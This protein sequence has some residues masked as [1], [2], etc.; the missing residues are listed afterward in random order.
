[1]SL[2][3]K[4][5][6]IQIAFILV[7]LVSLNFAFTYF[8][9]AS[10]QQRDTKQMER[11]LARAAF[12]IKKEQQ[13][14]YEVSEIWAKSDATWEF[15]RGYNP[16]FEEADINQRVMSMMN[17]SSFV[18]FDN[19]NKPALLKNFAAPI[20]QTAPQR[21]FRKLIID[22]PKSAEMLKNI[23]ISGVKGLTNSGGKPV[24]FVLQPILNPSEE[25]KRGGFLL[26]TE[27]LDKNM[28]DT[29][30]SESGFKF[31]LEPI[32]SDDTET[33]A[34]EQ[35]IGN[36]LSRT[37]RMSGQKLVKDYAG[38]PAFWITIS[39]KKEAS[40]AAERGIHF[41][42]LVLALIA[43]LFSLNNNRVLSSKSAHAEQE[44][45]KGDTPPPTEP[46]AGI[47]SAATIS[48][49]LMIQ[50]AEAA[51]PEDTPVDSISATY[52]P[53]ERAFT[54][55]PTAIDNVVADP[56]FSENTEN[57]K[58]EFGELA[59]KVYERFVCDCNKLCY[60][61]CEDLA[62]V[63]TPRDE[64]FK[65]SIIRGAR[66]A[67]DFAQAM[68][69]SADDSLF[70]YYGAL[71]SR[72]GLVALPFPIRKN[73]WELNDEELLQYKKYPELSHQI[74]E[75]IELLRPASTI[76]H[77]WKENWDGTGFP[78]KFKGEEI[79]LEGRIFAIVNDWNELTRMWQG[80][81]LPT[82]MEIESRLRRRA[83]TRLD[84]RLVEE[85]IKFQRKVKEETPTG[86]RNLG[87]TKIELKARKAVPPRSRRLSNPAAASAIGAKATQRGMP[88]AGSRSRGPK[89]NSG[90]RPVRIMTKTS[91]K[92]I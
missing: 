64:S 49:E 11:L 30:S 71:F 25:S 34:E 78:N 18:L 67:S 89:Q 79:P 15:M 68:G 84:P 75:S 21:D 85:F 86:P 36:S 63:L 37:G 43:A 17:V 73:K 65:R 29:I 69:I 90:K 38:V 54:I 57:N 52:V 91:W 61:T 45:S 82:A 92:R 28:I 42:M 2:Q 40:S 12:L 59:V 44:T 7:L 66:K 9:R 83:G 26:V 87:C 55:E 10:H 47:S 16:D 24:L 51:A 1:M 13:R 56:Q 72:I 31:A 3:R 58:E 62:V 33:I 50:A 70:V 77:T 5:I 41:T 35:V 80:R 53:K 27:E 19:N 8:L 46:T 81:A 39:L 4:K 22:N 74:M 20:D 32:G 60:R 23:P 88:T 14:L 76:P 48:P 6:F